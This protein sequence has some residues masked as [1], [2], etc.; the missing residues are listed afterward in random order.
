MNEEEQTIMRVSCYSCFFHIKSKYLY[1]SITIC[2]KS[3]E[4]DE[5]ILINGLLNYRKLY[6][7]VQMTNLSMDK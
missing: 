6:R 3:K 5:I 4:E 1:N 7:T 2:V